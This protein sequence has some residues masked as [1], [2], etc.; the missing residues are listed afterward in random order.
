MN[1]YCYVTTPIY[2]VNDNPH[3]GHAYT[4]IA[5]DVYARF[6]RMQGKKVLFLT[7]SDEHGQKVEKAAR[8]FGYDPQQFTDMMSKKFEQLA[9]CLNISPDDFIRTTQERHQQ[10]AVALWKALVAH[11]DIYLG[12]YQGWY[13]VRDEHFINDSDVVKDDKGTGRSL[14]GEKVEW[15][16]EESYFFRLSHWQDALLDHYKKHPDSIAPPSRMKEVMTFIEQGLQDISISRTT[17][18]WGIDVPPS[19]HKPALATKKHHVMY[20][21]IDALANY[22][23]ALGY[24]DW[25]DHKHHFWPASLHMIGKDILRFH[26]VY[27]PAFLMAAQLPLPARIFAHGWWTNEGEKISKSLGNVIDPFSLCREWGSDVIRYF[28]LR[29][30]PFGSDGNFSKHS[31][32]QR[33]NSDL[34]NGIG[35]LAMRV[36]TLVQRHCDGKV[37]NPSHLQTMDDKAFLKEIESLYPRVR[38]SLEE[39]AFH[40]ALHHIWHSISLSDGY[41]DRQQPWALKK[42]DVKRMHHVLYVLLE[43]LCSIALTLLPFMPNAMGRLC[44]FLA[45]PDSQRSFGDTNVLRVGERLP[46]PQPLF[47]RKS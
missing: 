23:S 3:I 38:K 45:I 1:S 31:L 47:P 39:Q 12:T 27:W 43:A 2:Y 34:A 46:P 11:G 36:L 40:T 33:A 21:W 5:C 42:T 37:P 25:D 4:S 7:G 6:Q 16:E 15:L 9:E 19:P 13:S 44:S 35:N 26:A 17:F 28:L 41:I 20:V 10:G 29:E 24:P 8:R 30:I 18:S 14:Q 22:L 32:M